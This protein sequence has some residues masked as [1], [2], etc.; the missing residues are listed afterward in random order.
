MQGESLVGSEVEA[1]GLNAR[2]DLNGARGRVLSFDAAKGRCAVLFGG[3]TPAVLIKPC[4]LSAVPSVQT[5]AGSPAVLRADAGGGSVVSAVAVALLRQHYAIVD[6]FLPGGADPLHGLLR[7]LHEQGDLQLGDVAGGRAA[8]TYARITGQ[9]LPRGDLMRWLDEEEVSKHTV[10]QAALA[11]IDELLLGLQ[12]APMLA[13]ELEGCQLCRRHN[14]VQATCY[15]SGARYVRHVDNN[16]DTADDGRPERRRADGRRSGRRVTCII[17]ANP[18]WRAGL[19][20]WVDFSP[21]LIG[22]VKRQCDGWADTSLP[23]GRTQTGSGAHASSSAQVT[24]VSCGSTRQR[25][26]RRSTCSPSR[27]DS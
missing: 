16:D 12:S 13:E 14:E 1:H 7:Q 9:P 26:A 17:Y 3:S 10:L 22:G 21:R 23:C 8:A 27:T 18:E 6:A 5:Y 25:A 4:N 11:S 19:Y 2:A 24:V 20:S 15:Q